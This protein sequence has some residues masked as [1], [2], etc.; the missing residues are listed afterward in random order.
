MSMVD[1][2]VHIFI[3]S[4]PES[5]SLQGLGGFYSCKDMSTSAQVGKLRLR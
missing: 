3:F 5:P 2:F 4:S 1:S